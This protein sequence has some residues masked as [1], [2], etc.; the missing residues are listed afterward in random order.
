MDQP[1]V[2]ADCLAALA[3][4]SYDRERV[5]ESRTLAG[6]AEDLLVRNHLQ[7]RATSMFVCSVVGLTQAR[8]G[9]PGRAAATLAMVRDMTAATT[10]LAPWLTVAVDVLRARTYLLLGDVGQARQLVRQARRSLDGDSE[11][12]VPGGRVVELETLLSQMS[13]G[14][15]YGFS[16]ITASELRVLRLLPSCLS[17]SEMGELLFISR[18]TVKSHAM[19][20]YRKL[21][22][23][24]RSQVVERACSLGYLPVSVLPQVPPFD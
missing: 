8:A 19:S 20:I 22:A 2:Q 13:A 17:F 6:A 12:S 9:N 11:R 7:D 21:D 24:T 1:A 18:Y 15:T 5:D 4:V 14:L 10:H 3:M 16:P 23:S